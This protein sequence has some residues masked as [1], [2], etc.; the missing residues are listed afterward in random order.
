MV[1][2]A[3]AE[4]RRLEVTYGL[5]PALVKALGDQFQYAVGLRD[6]TTLHFEDA[7][8]E[9]GSAWVH[10]SG[11]GGPDG[12]YYQDHTPGDISYVSG[13]GMDIRISE[14]V[15]AADTGH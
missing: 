15:W 10:L 7:S 3:Q 13:R 4:A 6:G 12:F 9:E 2:A 1:R 14:I 8:Y 11:T 5:P